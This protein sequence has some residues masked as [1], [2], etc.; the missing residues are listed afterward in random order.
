V[1]TYVRIGN[2]SSRSMT[3]AVSVGRVGFGDDGKA[4]V[5]DQLDPFWAGRVHLGEAA[6]TVPAG[7]YA[8][9]RVAVSLPKI[10][11]PDDYY[12]GLLVT[13]QATGPGAVK[14]ITRLATLI[15][16]DVPGPRHS[17]VRLRAVH[18]PRLVL[19]ADLPVSAIVENTGRSFTTV[20]GEV[21]YHSLFG[22]EKVAEFPGRFVVAPGRQRM[23]AVTL[24][25]G[26]GAGPVHVDSMVFYN[27]TP[28]AVAELSQT[29]MVWWIDPPYLPLVLTGI[30]AAGV[31]WRL[32][33]RRPRRQQPAPALARP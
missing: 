25:P 23:V 31:A 7:S 17:L 5:A 30:A 15:D 3:V 27:R 11:A 32:G 24:H 14:V 20:W 9:D 33:R 29:S 1:S 2:T 21:H 13:P 8:E 22:A 6:L 16:F 10:A 4:T 26:V 19:G 12:L 18:V 28:S